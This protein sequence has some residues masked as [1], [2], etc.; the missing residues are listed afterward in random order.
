MA[1]KKISASGD[2]KNSR[3]PILESLNFLF[4]ISKVF[5]MIPYSLSDYVT[6]KQFKLSQLGNILCVLSCIHYT[7]HYQVLTASSTLAKDDESSIGTLTTVIGVIIVYLE[8]FMF[9]VDVLASML[10]QK[11]LIAIFERLR[12]IDDKLLKE[13]VSLSYRAIKKYS[14]ILVATAALGE[15]TIGI[16][17]LAIFE[18]SI[19]SSWSLYWIL[20]CVPL[21]NNCLAR[22][23]FLILILL[24]QQ[25]LRA[26]NNY[27]NGTKNAFLKKKSRNVSVNGSNLKK[28]NLFMENLGYLEREIFSTRNTKI[29]SDNAWNWV[30]NSK[31]T[32]AVNDV[33]AIGPK[34]NGF[35]N[36]GPYDPNGKGDESH[37]EVDW[38]H[39][40]ENS[41]AR[42]LS[43]EPTRN[44]YWWTASTLTS[45]TLWSAT[46]WIKN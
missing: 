2:K 34:S 24:V 17:N 22:T 41:P 26:I 43:Q 23:W 25:R 14:I 46:K 13:S 35:I 44:R 38:L 28:D 32:G 31:L 21:F 4:Y 1:E 18:E 12:E 6:K 27:L 8:P 45:M 15:V 39:W 3:S 36:V 40:T 11:S 9:A 16:F 29:K 37:S 33:S 42:S 10:N 30:G 20:S 19:I 5:G 7:I